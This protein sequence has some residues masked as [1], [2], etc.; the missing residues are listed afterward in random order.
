MRV[1]LPPASATIQVGPKQH[2]SAGMEGWVNVAHVACA[3]G[4][5]EI[6]RWVVT[7]PTTYGGGQGADVGLGRH[8][9][10]DLLLKDPRGR[11]A[12]HYCALADN[13]QL[14]DTLLNRTTVVPE[15]RRAQLMARDDEG[16]TVEELIS[17]RILEEGRG[18]NRNSRTVRKRKQPHKG[19][20]TQLHG[21][22][23]DDATSW[24]HESLH[25]IQ[26]AKR[27]LT[28]QGDTSRGPGDDVGPLR[29]AALEPQR[30]TR[31]RID[32]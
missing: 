2:L 31:G 9:R 25:V 14:L 1:I 24:L 3:Y 7:Q 12:I 4:E 18:K 10:P 17:S 22:R 20:G 8:V 23:M 29:D 19:V 15:I 13:P 21:Q 5:L 27:D 11:L 16:R 26:A 30:H 32:L 6:L 28:P